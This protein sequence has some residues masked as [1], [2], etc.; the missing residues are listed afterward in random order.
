MGWPEE[1]ESSGVSN[2]ASIT[3]SGNMCLVKPKFVIKIKT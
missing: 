2:F 1:K 3:D